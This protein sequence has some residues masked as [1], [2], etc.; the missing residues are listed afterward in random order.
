[1]LTSRAWVL[2]RPD[3]LSIQSF[4]IEQQELVLKVCAVGLCGTDVHALRG[5]LPL[6]Y[7]VVLGHEIVGR[8]VGADGRCEVDGSR[9]LLAPTKPC[10]ECE[11][12]LAATPTRCA[13]RKTIG[14]DVESVCVPRGG[15]SEYI[16][17]PPG[18]H[19]VPVPAALPTELAVLAEPL[20]C[21]L[22]ALGRARSVWPIAGARVA[23]LGAG[24]IGL[25]TAVTAALLGGHVK[26][27]EPHTHRRHLATAL[28]FEVVT[29]EVSQHAK[30]D[31]VIDCAGTTQAV[32]HA[33]DLVHRGGVVTIFGAF[34]AAENLMLSPAVICTR[35][36]SILGAS[37]THMDD[38]ATALRLLNWN[39]ER[40]RPIV[41]HEI[42][43]FGSKS[44]QD[45]VDLMERGECGKIYLKP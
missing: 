5:R 40:Y 39:V 14:I 43:M 19:L 32:E 18:F 21:V 12:C 29:Q 22:S 42:P 1:M 26:I 34:A 20:A 36:L 9:F 6:A 16:A 7:P 38:Y 13:S 25:L 27:F 15:F 35:E 17:V 28:G 3:Q 37:T 31:H 2:S 33:L 23:V 41:T 24:P 8:L 45:A 11:A 30:L 4:D 44:V 10:L